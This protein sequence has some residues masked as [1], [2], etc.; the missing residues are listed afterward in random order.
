MILSGPWTVD[1]K[2]TTIYFTLFLAFLISCFFLI[3]LFL[4]PKSK[5]FLVTCWSYFCEILIANGFL[6][7]LAIAFL[8]ALILPVS[9]L[10]AL[11]G[12]WGESNGIL[13]ASVLGTLCLITN[14]CWTY[15]MARVFGLNLINRFIRLLKRNPI[16]IPDESENTNFFL[17]SLFLRLTPG[18]PF[19]FSNLILGAVKMP[20]HLYLLISIPILTCS[21]F[22]YIYATAGLIGGDFANLGG[23]VAVILCFLIVGRIILKKKKNAV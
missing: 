3:D 5:D 7:F 1:A 4:S 16:T 2:K 11:A 15:W 13:L 10:L 19:I 8:P 17:W 6:L 21:S 12:I 9:P 22:G 18:I 23:G 14:C 20:F